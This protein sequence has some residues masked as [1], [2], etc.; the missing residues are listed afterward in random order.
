MSLLAARGKLCALHACIQNRL[1]K[2]DSRE[3]SRAARKWTPPLLLV[4]L[5]ISRFRQHNDISLHDTS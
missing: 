4:P 3:A 5:V 1:L 2:D